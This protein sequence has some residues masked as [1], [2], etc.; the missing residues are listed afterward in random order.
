MEID[1]EPIA[2]RHGKKS[3]RG[4]RGTSDRI[5]AR[6]DSFNPFQGTKRPAADMHVERI[7]VGK[8]EVTGKPGGDGK[9][10]L[11]DRVGK[12]ANDIKKGEKVNIFGLLKGFLGSLGGLFTSF[13]AM[14]MGTLGKLAL[15]F[16]PLMGILAKALPLLGGAAAVAGAAA[17]GYYVGGKIN[18]AANWVAEKITGRQGETAQS[19]IVA[20]VDKLQEKAGGL[21]GKSSAMQ[22]KDD[23]VKA[24]TKRFGELLKLQGGEMTSKQVAF[25]KGQGV[26][27]SAAKVNENVTVLGT[28]NKPVQPRKTME[29]T[30]LVPDMIPKNQLMPD[31]S[32]AEKARMASG[33]KDSAL[34][35]PSAAISR[36]TDMVDSASRQLEASKEVRTAKPTVVV[37]NVGGGSGGDKMQPPPISIGAAR[38]QEN[39]FA[40]YLAS[41]FAAL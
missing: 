32:P 20:G 4:R 38:N 7:V 30:D 33:G 39:A 18:D 14:F 12:E 11:A 13:G 23:E 37:N 24:S 19:A 26:D 10:S 8:L 22:Q 15:A 35:A 2:M 36:R 31:E 5:V 17:A 40:R 6:G 28:D 21:L 9:E 1:G 34:A 27:V 29:T 16:G 41:N 3:R 25:W